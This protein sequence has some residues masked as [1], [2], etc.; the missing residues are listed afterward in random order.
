MIM[1][2]KMLTDW[3][4]GAMLPSE[5]MFL[6][7]KIL[8]SKCDLIVECGRQDAYSTVI[9]GN[10]AKKHNIE[11]LS[12]DFDDNKV[13]LDNSINKLLGLPVKCISGDIHFHVPTIIKDHSERRIAIIQ[14]G[15]KGWEGLSTLLAAVFYDQVMLIAQHNLHIG[16][17]S[18]NYFSSIPGG[19]NAFLESTNNEELLNFRRKELNFFKDKKTLREVDITSLGIIS[20]D[21]DRN[22]IKRFIFYSKEFPKY[23]SPINTYI[24]WQINNLDYVSKLKSGLKYNLARFITR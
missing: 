10:F 23:W 8:A 2:I 18:R 22:D 16:H 15:P 7:E 6:Q 13:M 9:L 12:I 21:K 1:D 11:V 19:L 17:K 5:I 14:D 3:I 24:N 4:D 20:L